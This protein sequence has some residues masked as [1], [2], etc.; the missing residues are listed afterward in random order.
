MAVVPAG[1]LTGAC[2]SGNYP[3]SQHDETVWISFTV[4]STVSTLYAG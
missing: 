4:F 2:I 3:P 1:S